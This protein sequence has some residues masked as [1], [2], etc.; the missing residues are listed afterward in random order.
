PWGVAVFGERK[1]HL[2][3]RREL[4]IGAMEQAVKMARTDEA[5]AYYLRFRAWDDYIV[6]LNAMDTADDNTKSEALLGNAWIYQ[7]LTSYRASAAYYLREVACDFES[8]VAAHLSHAAHLYERIAGEV[9]SDKEHMPPRI[10]PFP[11]GPDDGKFWTAE[12][13]RE[14]VRRL[15]AALPLER[16]AIGEIEVALYQITSGAEFRKNK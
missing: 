8:P 3:T 15:E 2:A 14:Q 5:E 13:R 7:C 16:E 12:M 1:P 9:L 10:A 11:G 4:A 6:R